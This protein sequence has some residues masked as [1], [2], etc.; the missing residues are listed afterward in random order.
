MHPLQR[1]P[2]KKKGFSCLKGNQYLTSCSDGLYGTGFKAA[3]NGTVEIS[4]SV[5]LTAVS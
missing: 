3:A 5:L 1:I 2:W 4:K